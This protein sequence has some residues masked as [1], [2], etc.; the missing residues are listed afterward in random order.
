MIMTFEACE[1]DMLLKYSCTGL[2]NPTLKSTNTVPRKKTESKAPRSPI[3]LGRTW[4]TQGSADS[5]TGKELDYLSP[6]RT[7]DGN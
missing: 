1:I 3:K 6:N 5:Q 2:R 7:V 4:G